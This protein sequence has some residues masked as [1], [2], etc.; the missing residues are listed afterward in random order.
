MR[1]FV[2]LFVA[3]ILFLEV[4]ANGG[5][6]ATYVVEPF[7]VAQPV[8]AGMTF[9]VYRTATLPQGWFLTYDG[10]AV[11]QAP[12][13]VWFYGSSAGSGQIVRTDF[14]VGSVVPTTVPLVPYISIQSTPVQNPAAHPMQSHMM[15]PSWSNDGNF[16]MVAQWRNFV[17]R[18]AV[19]N[20]PRVPLAWKGDEPT[21]VFAWTGKS[22]YQMKARKGETAP[23]VLQRHLYSL[24]RMVKSNHYSWNDQET[25]LLA[26]QSVLWGFLWMGH[27]APINF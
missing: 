22:W 20:Q 6:C 9:H 5:A 23:Q 2:W 18:M 7:L 25:P 14:V 10:Y 8:Y 11:T 24:T 13:G 26:N 19:L 15:L 16:Q 21:V 3:A 12:G 1:R 27:V 4:L 17:D